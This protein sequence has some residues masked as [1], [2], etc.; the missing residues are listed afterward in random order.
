VSATVIVLCRLTEL[1]ATGCREFRIG[2]GD[3]PLR[4]FVV[5]SE[6]GVRA[7]LNRCPHLS[8]PLNCLPDD[9]LSY[10]R[11]YLQCKMHGALFEKDSGL[12]IAGPCLGRRL[13]ALPLRV[14]DDA[15]VVDA[16]AIVHLRE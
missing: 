8:Y 14:D 16:Q 7:Y 5:Q 11:H 6:Q 12:C 2:D 9:F 3:W 13:V 1:R 10:D 15:V 4:G